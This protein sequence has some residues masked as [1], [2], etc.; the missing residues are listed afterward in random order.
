MGLLPAE[1]PHY[2]YDLSDLSSQAS[3]SQSS[4]ASDDE[5]TL[6]LEELVFGRQSQ[7]IDRG[8]RAHGLSVGLV[9]FAT[10]PSSSTELQPG[11]RRIVLPETDAPRI[12]VS[13]L[14]LNASLGLPS[15][16]EARLREIML[17][18][19]HDTSGTSGSEWEDAEA[20]NVAAGP[21]VLLLEGP[22]DVELD[23]KGKGFRIFESSMENGRCNALRDE[24]SC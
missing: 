1:V 11:V 23:P 7:G 13:L 10:A 24:N 17:Q 5:A 6:S 21:D 9:S 14:G 3:P 15:I 16:K 22:V 4:N 12:V 20:R 18:F 2:L 8:I 19:H